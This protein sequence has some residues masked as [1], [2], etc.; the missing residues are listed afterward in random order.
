MKKP[1]NYLLQMYR[2]L[3]E[4]MCT[5]CWFWCIF[6]VLA[7]SLHAFEVFAL[8]LQLNFSKIRYELQFVERK[9]R[10]YIRC[11]E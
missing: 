11:S 4:M 9:K 7:F 1:L 2:D 5:N 10:H 3:A 8:S 6:V